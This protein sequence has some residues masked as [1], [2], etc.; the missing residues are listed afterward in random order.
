M[1]SN[2]AFSCTEGQLDFKSTHGESNMQ[3]AGIGGFRLFSI[4]SCE[5][6]LSNGVNFISPSITLY[7]KHSDEIMAAANAPPD[8]HPSTH[9][10]DGRTF[11]SFFVTSS[12]IIA[13]GLRRSQVKEQRHSFRDTGKRQEGDKE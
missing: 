9:T 2:L 13:F 11:L 7:R 3:E 10:S 8:P 6:S 12:K 1:I 5:S 4:V